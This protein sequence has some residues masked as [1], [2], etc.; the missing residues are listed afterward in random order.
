MKLTRP[1]RRTGPI[2]PT[3]RGRIRNEDEDCDEHVFRN[4]RALTA[5]FGQIPAPR[6]LLIIKPSA[7]GDIVHA[8]PVLP[9]LRRLW[10]RAEITWL[11]TPACAPLVRDHPMIDHVILFDRKRLAGG[12][13]N[14]AAFYELCKFVIDLRERNFDLVIDLQG[15]FRSAWVA[16]ASG[17]TCR[18]GFSNAREGAPLFYTHQVDCS[19]EMD[20]AVERYLKIATALGCPDG[21]VQTT[22][23]VGDEDRRYIQSLLPPGLRYA[24]LMPGTLWETKRLPAERFAELVRPL[25]EK[26]GLATVLAGS[27]A[28]SQFASLIPAD[29]NLCGKTNL[30]QIVALLERADLVVAN[31]TGPMHMAAALGRPLVT[32]YGPTSPIRTGPFG[33]MDSVIQ[34]DLR[35]SPCYSRTCSHQSCMQ[36]IDTE[37]LLS[38]AQIQVISS[39]RH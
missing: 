12:W 16:L 7:I 13:Y 28:D 35:C 37:S 11:V 15:L 5:V 6:R 1:I 19:W 30:R 36:W 33:R 17:A 27:P 18:V 23:V 25:K 32:P 9:R 8:L 10:P 39:V 22:L 3:T 20:H 26:F 38:L 29:F 4:E 21:P 14:P 31:D 34:L 2:K 24:V